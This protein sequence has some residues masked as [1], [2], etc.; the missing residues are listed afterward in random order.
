MISILSAKFRLFLRNPWMV[1]IMSIV[2]IVMASVI[3][4]SSEKKIKVPVVSTLASHETNELLQSLNKSPSFRFELMEKSKMRTLV[5]EG[6]VEA[7]V[8][9]SNHD[10]TLIITSQTGN[11]FF[12]RQYVQKVYSEKEQ[13]NAIATQAHIPVEKAIH[14]VNEAKEHPAFTVKTMNFRG[15]HA[16]TIDSQLQ[17]IFGFSLFFVIYTV[18]FQVLQ[19][20]KEKRE[21]VWNRMILSRLKKWEIYTG[22]LL[23]SFMIGYLQVVLIFSVFRFGLGIRF[24]G[25]FAELLLLLVP[26]VFSLVAFSML[27]VGLVKNEQQFQALISLLAVSMAMIGGAYWP[28]EIVSSNVLLALA[29]IVPL[30]YGMELL[31]G[32]AVYGRSITEL[33]YPMSILFFMGVVFMGIGI[34]LV[35]RKNG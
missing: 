30:T 1:I 24:H 35:E 33:L 3:G 32:A 20:L 12:L 22:N 28:L 21:G 10:F 23:Y 29:K 27:L 25:Q 13:T 5:Q 8:E 17:P 15:K 16:V 34:N 31:K 11:T 4:A 19:L 14:I 26:Y 9:L 18:A 2:C 7:G 6:K